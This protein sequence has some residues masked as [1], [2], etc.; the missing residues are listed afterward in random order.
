MQFSNPSKNL[1]IRHTCETKNESLQIISNKLIRE[2]PVTISVRL[3]SLTLLQYNSCHVK[4]LVVLKLS[5]VATYGTSRS[6]CIIMIMA[7]EIGVTEYLKN[8]SPT[9]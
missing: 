4:R 8:W 9:F 1:V 3:C 6:H 2:L 5:K 7:E